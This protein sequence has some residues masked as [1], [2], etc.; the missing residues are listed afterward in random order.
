MVK[1]VF[2]ITLG[3]IVRSSSLVGWVPLALFYVFK[4]WDYF[5]AILKAGIFVA[6]PTIGLSILNDSYFY[7]YWC[8]P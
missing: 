7:G 3:F 4:S 2:A 8:F 6:I 1:M 5:V